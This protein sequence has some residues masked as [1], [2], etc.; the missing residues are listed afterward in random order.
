MCNVI[1]ICYRSVAGAIPKD[2]F[3]HVH[4]YAEHF[5]DLLEKLSIG[6]PYTPILDKVT[7]FYVLVYLVLDHTA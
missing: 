1:S 2:N 7:T 5:V 4:Y 3:L 6:K